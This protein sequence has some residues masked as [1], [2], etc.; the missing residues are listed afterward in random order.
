MQAKLIIILLVGEIVDCEV[1][2]LGE[3]WRLEE[4]DELRCHEDEAFMKITG[5]VECG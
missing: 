3:V 4:L 5:L 1:C 2:S